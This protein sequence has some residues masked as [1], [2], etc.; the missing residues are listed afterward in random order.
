MMSLSHA[1]TV[2]VTLRTLIQSVDDILPSLHCSVTTEVRLTSS[3]FATIVC[4]I[5]VT[6]YKLNR[7]PVQKEKCKVCRASYF[8]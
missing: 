3:L 7:S 1:Q 4:L 8:T 2:G 5:F 6:I